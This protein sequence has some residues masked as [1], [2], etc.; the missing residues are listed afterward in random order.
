MVN[1]NVGTIRYYVLK[2]W[3]MVQIEHTIVGTTNGVITI[4]QLYITLS[5]IMLQTPVINFSIIIW[6]IWVMKVRDIMGDHTNLLR[7][8]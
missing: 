5:I 7:I 2:P 8:L 3:Y 4:N 6:A 1:D